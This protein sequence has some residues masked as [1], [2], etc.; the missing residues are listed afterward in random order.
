MPIIV[1]S[2]IGTLNKVLLHRPGEELEHF[3][4]NS[5]ERLLFDD[6][7]FLR[8]AQAEHDEFAS[9]LR[10]NGC[11][12]CYLE[13]LTAEVLREDPSLRDDFIEDVILNSGDS[14]F[15]QHRHRKPVSAR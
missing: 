14:C 2:E 1:K 15:L 6:I 8:K 3:I 12:V 4:P 7:P 5:L 13:D 9:I 10:D 11:E